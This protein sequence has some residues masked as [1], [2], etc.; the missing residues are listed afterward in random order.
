MPLWDP[1]V[2]GS[3]THSLNFRKTIRERFPPVVSLHSP[4]SSPTEAKRGARL[5]FFRAPGLCA[6]LARDNLGRVR[7]HWSHQYFGSN[8]I[9]QV[10]Y[11]QAAP[12]HQDCG[13]VAACWPSFASLAATLVA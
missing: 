11:R 4:L 7:P 10:A 3:G 12:N 2:R 1:G 5:I 6:S 8:G 9:S 13:D